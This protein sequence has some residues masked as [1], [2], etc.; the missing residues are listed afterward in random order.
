MDINKEVNVY[1]CSKGFRFGNSQ[2]E[3]TEVCC[4]M[5]I[6]VGGVKRKILCYVIDGTAPILFGRPVM[7]RLGMAVDFSNKKVRYGSDLA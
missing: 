4:L 2:R 3:T 1:Y 7:E 6:Y 5:P